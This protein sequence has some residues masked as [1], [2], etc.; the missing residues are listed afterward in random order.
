MANH[1]LKVLSINAADV[2]HKFPME[3][4]N[5]SPRDGLH[6]INVLQCV[7]ILYLELGTYGGLTRTEDYFRQGKI[8]GTLATAKNLR[9]LQLNLDYSENRPVQQDEASSFSALLR[10]CHFPKLD[11]LCLWAFDFSKDKL[12]SFFR[13][14]SETLV[15]LSIYDSIMRSGLWVDLLD[16]ARQVLH[17]QAVVVEEVIG[18]WEDGYGE[19]RWTNSGAIEDF[20]L[21][22]GP[23]P[24]TRKALDALLGIKDAEERHTAPPE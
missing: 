12:L 9:S 6:L 17:L 19:M 16:R 13:G 24:L 15:D 2:R 3:A 8:A 21:R 11:T 10:N 22:N 20:F 14:H 1:P 23:N 4:F 7:Q 18:G 5:T